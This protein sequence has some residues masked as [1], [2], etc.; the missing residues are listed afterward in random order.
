MKIE[1]ISHLVNLKWLDLSFNKIERIQGLSSLVQLT[2][3]SL[4]NNDI[5]VVEGLETLLN[6]SVLSL[7][8]NKIADVIQMLKH[9]KHL[10][11]LEVLRVGENH[12]THSEYKNFILVHLPEL[13]FLDYG[14]IY[15]EGEK[16]GE[17]GKYSLDINVEENKE[18]RESKE[19]EDDKIY[20]NLGLLDLYHYDEYL[21]KTHD[22]PNQDLIDLI[23]VPDVFDSALSIFSETIRGELTKILGDLQKNIEERDKTRE[24]L[25]KSFTWLQSRSEK[26]ALQLLQTY[27]SEK[28]HCDLDW[29][30]QDRVPDWRENIQNIL[31]TLESLDMKLMENEL[32]LVQELT[33]VFKIVK[34]KLDDS[35][36]IIT[37]TDIVK[38]QDFDSHIKTLFDSLTKELLKEQEKRKEENK[39]AEEEGEGSKEGVEEPEDQDLERDNEDQHDDPLESFLE[40]DIQTQIAQMKESVESANK[41]KV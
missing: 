35:L 12:F 5:I 40:D 15:K 19:E 23:K 30:E 26:R 21:L 25:K 11:K 29:E 24:D 34:G 22:A 8:R 7:G 2:D 32:E 13:K 18:K 36:N 10:K 33:D 6:L 4:Y 17:I 14:Y 39:A 20:R 1:N 9:I 28:K 31:K 38:M 37:N 3:L 41:A 16:I 27:Q